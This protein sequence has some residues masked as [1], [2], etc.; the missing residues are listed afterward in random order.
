MS[1]DGQTWTELG[2]SPDARL[3]VTPLADGVVRQAAA[4]RRDRAIERP[5]DARRLARPGQRHLPALRDAD[6]RHR[7]LAGKRNRLG[8]RVGRR[9]EGVDVMQN[10]VW[11][12]RF[13]MA[14]RRLNPVARDGSQTWGW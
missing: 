6:H 13:L 9:D 8:G 12:Q 10:R 7:D 3:R 11:R 4:F 5:V 14:R 1:A 2:S